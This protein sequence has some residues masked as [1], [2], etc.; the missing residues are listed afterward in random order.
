MGTEGQQGVVITVLKRGMWEPLW[1]PEHWD[2][3]LVEKKIQRKSRQFYQFIWNFQGCKSEHRS[4]KVELEEHHWT[5]RGFG[6]LKG[7]VKREMWGCGPVRSA[8]SQIYL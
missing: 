7:Y 5:E 8:C 1:W 6:F 4:V 2:L 3:V